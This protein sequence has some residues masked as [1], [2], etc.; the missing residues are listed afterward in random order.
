M[1]SHR[2]KSY[3]IKLYTGKIYSFKAGELLLTIVRRSHGG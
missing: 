1:R 2:S 3:A